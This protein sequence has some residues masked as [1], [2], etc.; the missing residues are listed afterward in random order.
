MAAAIRVGLDFP[1]LQINLQ[2]LHQSTDKLSLF[3]RRFE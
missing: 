1:I 3:H 2:D